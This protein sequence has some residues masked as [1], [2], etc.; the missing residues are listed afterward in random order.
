MSSKL[1]IFSERNDKFDIDDTIA[2]I[3]ALKGISDPRR[4]E[5]IGAI[6]EADFESN[7]N[8]TIVRISTDAE[9]ITAEGLGDESLMFALSLQRHT[10]IRLRAVDM[11]DS[12]DL[13]LVDIASIDAFRDAIEKR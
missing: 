7:G 9:T 13:M 12:S 5:F 4:G 2:L 6:F 11:D 10:A 1:L 3:E 8:T